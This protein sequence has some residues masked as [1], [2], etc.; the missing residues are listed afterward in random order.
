MPNKNNLTA[1]PMEYF[2]PYA[3]TVVDTTESSED[4]SKSREQVKQDILE[5]VLE[6]FECNPTMCGG[7]K[8]CSNI[9]LLSDK[10][11]A[12]IKNYIGRNDIKPIN[13]HNIFSQEYI[14]KC[15]FLDDKTLRCMIRPVEPEICKSFFCN[16]YLK[17]K[18]NIPNY[19][20]LHVV[21]ML[22]T[23][24]PGAY[25]PNSPNLKEY[26]KKFKNLKKKAYN[27]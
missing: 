22:L 20:Q 4:V 11:I 15:P 10:E 14:D 2:D 26:E 19:R 7:A 27:K 16:T 12:R 1:P 8:C 17:K 13:R 3:E 21:N 23:F 18:P 9:L 5:S 24:S 6:N 25:C